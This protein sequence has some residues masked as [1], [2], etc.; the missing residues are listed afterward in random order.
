MNYSS[1]QLPNERW[2]IYE[3]GKLLATIG[4]YQTCHRILN[5][6]AERESGNYNKSEN[7]RSLKA[8]TK[9]LIKVSNFN[10]SKN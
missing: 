10:V 1:E 5:L 4:C 9:K 7:W 3:R 6:L 8:K 2:G